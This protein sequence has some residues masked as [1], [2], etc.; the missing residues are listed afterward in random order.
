MNLMLQ[1]CVLFVHSVDVFCEHKYFLLLFGVLF[2]LV[3]ADGLVPLS[4]GGGLEWGGVEE[5]GRAGAVEG[6]GL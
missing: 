5:A 3:A 6:G 1:I 2:E 4:A